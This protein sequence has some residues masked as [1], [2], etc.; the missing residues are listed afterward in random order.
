MHYRRTVCDGGVFFFTATL[1]DRRRDTLVRH[2]DELRA[3]LLAAKATH[4]FTLIAMVVLPEHLHAIWRLPHGDCN[5][6]LRWSLFKAGFS[7]RLPKCE[8]IDAARTRKR[9]R[10]VWQRRYWEHQIRDAADLAQH[11]DYIH[12]NPVKHGL[13]RRPS[14][15]PHSTFHGYV[16]RGWLARDWGGYD[17]LRQKRFGE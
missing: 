3:S 15:W 14:D 4:P 5:Y 8:P 13:A 6:P 2:V 9:E 7:R 11:V 12:F 1:A 17:S 16:E 10:G